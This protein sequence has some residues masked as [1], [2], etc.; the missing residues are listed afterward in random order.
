MAKYRVSVTSSFC[1]PLGAA[2]RPSSLAREARDELSVSL[3]NTTCALNRQH[4]LCCPAPTSGA[5][6]P[7]SWRRLV[8]VRRRTLWGNLHLLRRVVS[9]A[10]GPNGSDFGGGAAN[11]PHWA[12]F[13]WLLDLRSGATCCCRPPFGLSFRRLLKL[14]SA[15]DEL[16]SSWLRN[17]A[18]GEI[19]LLG[20]S[21]EKEEGGANVSKK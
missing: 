20:A 14:S 18:G 3:S 6:G 21:A 4:E 15:C 13:C 8:T 17:G 10:S 2:R 1:F 11:C 9:S 19:S 5:R 16:K 12:R 7:S